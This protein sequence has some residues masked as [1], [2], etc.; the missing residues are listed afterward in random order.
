M[1]A[2]PPP[3]APLYFIHICRSA[4]AITL[5]ASFCDTQPWIVKEWRQAKQRHVESR[6]PH[7]DTQALE[8]VFSDVQQIQKR[9]KIDA[10]KAR[11]RPHRAMA[12]R[13][14]KVRPS[15]ITTDKP[16]DLR[17]KDE[18][19]PHRSNSAHRG[20]RGR[21]STAGQLHREMGKTSQEVTGTLTYHGEAQR[22]ETA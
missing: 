4:S 10:Q 5:N 13:Q 8:H 2:S 20:R 3:A 17:G 11:A 19:D 9:A 18:D 7:P 12:R 15:E 16:A 22:A 21:I 1:A 14:G 6:D